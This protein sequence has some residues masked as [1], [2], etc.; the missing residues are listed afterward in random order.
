VLVFNYIITCYFK[1]L[2]N[3]F[4]VGGYVLLEVVERLTALLPIIRPRPVIDS[5]MTGTA[6][7]LSS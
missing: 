1:E 3:I 6:K 7:K 2:R 5:I 4:E